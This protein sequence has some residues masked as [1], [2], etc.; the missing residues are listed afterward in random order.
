MESD[1][2][3]KQCLGPNP[4]CTWANSLDEDLATKFIRENSVDKDPFFLYVSTTTPHVGF[5]NGHGP[6]PSWFSS[7]QPVPYEFSQSFLNQ[8]GS[9]WSAD[10]KQFAA[11]V[12]AQDAIVGSILDQLEASGIS[13]DT[14]VFFSG[15]NG[16]DDHQFNLFDDTG[17]FRGKKRSLH[18]GGRCGGSPYGPMCFLSSMNRGHPS[19]HIEIH[20]GQCPIPR[21]ARFL[22]V[23]IAL[24]EFAKLLWLSGQEP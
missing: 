3:Y 16:P 20:L 12:W 13:N 5:L 14:V 21:C 23:Y 18:E 19:S 1:L 6:T 22:T 10:L 4:T 24:Q 17:V 15:D 11:A 8:S 9:E 7:N 2:S